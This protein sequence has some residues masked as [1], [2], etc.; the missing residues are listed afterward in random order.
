[1]TAYAQ[2]T[3]TVPGLQMLL[4]PGRPGALRD[5]GAAAAVPALLADSSQKDSVPATVAA[6]E[7]D[8]NRNAR[9]ALLHYLDGEKRYIIA[10]AQV[11]VGD[12]LQSGQGAEIR[13]GNAPRCATSRSVRWSTTSS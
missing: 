13:P 11:K 9:I 6:I 12:Q 7:Y 1:M 8:P 4:L 3:D 2:D 5:A 10:P